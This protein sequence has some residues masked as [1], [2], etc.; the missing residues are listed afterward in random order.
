MSNNIDR[1]K[2]IGV[3]AVAAA[4]IIVG[5]TTKGKAN[6]KIYRKLFRC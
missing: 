6:R 1:R 2:F 3:G 4:G 5:C